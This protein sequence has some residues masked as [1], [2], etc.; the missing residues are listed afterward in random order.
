MSELFTPQ[1]VLFVKPLAT[2]PEYIPAL[3]VV[4]TPRTKLLQ[5]I[6]RALREGQ[7]VTIGDLTFRFCR[8]GCTFESG[9]QV[10]QALETGIFIRLQVFE[11]PNWAEPTSHRWGWLG[12]LDDHELYLTP[13]LDALTPEAR[14]YVAA[15]LIFTAVMRKLKNRSSHLLQQDNGR[16]G[17]EAAVL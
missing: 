8:K 15:D 13:Y 1:E 14:E 9:D 7:V 12:N 11:A 5:F 6:E 3:G 4:G 10:F 2:L 17:L 16:E